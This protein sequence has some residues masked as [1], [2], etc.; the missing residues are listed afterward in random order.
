MDVVRY[1]VGTNVNSKTEGE[2]I[3]DHRPVTVDVCLL[4]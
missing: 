3:T 4:P 1:E 2:L